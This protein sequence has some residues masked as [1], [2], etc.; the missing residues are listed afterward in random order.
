MAG[1]AWFRDMDAEPLA[2]GVLQRDD[3]APRRASGS[4]A[5][6]PMSL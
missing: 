5:A 1:C 4:P 2:R 6:E 3:L